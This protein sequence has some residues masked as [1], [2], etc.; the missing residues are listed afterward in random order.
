MDTRCLCP[1]QKP[2]KLKNRWFCDIVDNV[3]LQHSKLKWC[4]LYQWNKAEANF[5]TAV[6]WRHSLQVNCRKNKI[7]TIPEFNPVICHLLWR[8]IR[9]ASKC[10]FFGCVFIVRSPQT[11]ILK[12]HLPPLPGSFENKPVLHSGRKVLCCF[13][14]IQRRTPPR[15]ARFA[16][17][18]V[19]QTR[20]CL[21]NGAPLSPLCYM[22]IS[23]PLPACC[24]VVSFFFS[25]ALVPGRRCIPQGSSTHCCAAGVEGATERGWGGGVMR[26]RER[27]GFKKIKNKKTHKRQTIGS[28]GKAAWQLYDPQLFAGFTVK[29]EMPP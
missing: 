13:H 16:L 29:E 8:P 26:E 3:I 7:K 18:L 27:E 11:I 2:L 1:Q 23:F 10:N 15:T 22:L 17:A 4:T 25:L 24:F 6:W 14:C 12:H 5:R 20:P 19:P 9:L 28:R 21:M